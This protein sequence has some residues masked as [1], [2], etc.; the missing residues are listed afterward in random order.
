MSLKTLEDRFDVY[1]TNSWELSDVASF[2]RAYIVLLML[3][4]KDLSEN[5]LSAIL[6]RKKQ[7]RGVEFDRNELSELMKSFRKELD[8]NIRGA[9][10]S[11]RAVVLN[12]LVF[13]ALLEAEETDRFYMMEPMFE[14][15]REM[16]VSADKLK[17]VLESEF[18]GFKA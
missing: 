8:R 7:L 1:L 10:S 11:P 15:V 4:E 3:F 14:F 12:R 18:V 6:E 17:L 9:A 5:Q 13:C 16:N 2:S